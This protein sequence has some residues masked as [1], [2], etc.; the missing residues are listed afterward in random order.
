MS[1]H[2]PRRAL[3]V[4]AV[5]GLL[6]AG[7]GG[8]DQAE[9]EEATTA[10][11][12]AAEEPT[13]EETA[14][15]EQAGNVE[16]FCD[17]TVSTIAVV[18]T[19]PEVDFET[20]APEE[21]E[22]ALAAF[23][24]QT[25]PLLDDLEASA[26]EEI[27]ADVEQISGL[28]RQALEGDDTIFEQPEFIEADAAIDEYMLAECGFSELDVQG[29]DYGYEGVPETLEPGTY[30]VSFSNVGAEVHEM[31]LF[32]LAEDAGS[33][34][35]VLQLPEEELFAQLNIVGGAFAEPGQ[36]DVNFLTIDEPGRYGLVC[37]LPQGTTSLEQL[38]EQPPPGESPAADAP[39]PGPPHAS[40][41][42]V[43]EL[44]VE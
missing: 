18:S 30:S 32:R 27:S 31:L 7:C 5:F 40:L 41:G 37:F 39:T 13:P 25:T 22:E 42:M 43:A 12:E 35:E 34:E 44:T 16:E 9:T 11:T 2:T 14:A 17:T 33:V 29:V 38:E 26:P 36:T 21:I 19:G 24:E 6:L 1:N 28:I 15:T 4:I 3:V 20:A 10:E 23:A 8:G